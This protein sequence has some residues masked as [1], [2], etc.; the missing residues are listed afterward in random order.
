MGPI[1]LL[2][3]CIALARLSSGFSTITASFVVVTL[4]FADFL[5]FCANAGATISPKATSKIIFFIIK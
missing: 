1:I 2:S 4:A 5:D 3:D